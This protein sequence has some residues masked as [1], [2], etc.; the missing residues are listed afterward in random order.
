[1]KTII[2]YHFLIN[3]IVLFPFYLFGQ[4]K[5][6]VM[7]TP[8]CTLSINT[9][10]GKSTN[11]WINGI[12]RGKTPLEID[13][14]TPGFYDVSFLK[15]T[16]RDSILNLT[17]SSFNHPYGLGPNGELINSGSNSLF[18]S[19]GE[20]ARESNCKFNLNSNQKKQIIFHIQA[21]KDHMKKEE[22]KSKALITICVLAGSAL[23]LSCFFI[24]LTNK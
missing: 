8:N 4:D 23:L 2:R 6:N 11:I 24:L 22:R 16:L 21:T 7:N 19:A 18:L 15:P 5:S 1:M 3:F 12:I 17:N 14:L 9:D 13:T 10:N 20:L